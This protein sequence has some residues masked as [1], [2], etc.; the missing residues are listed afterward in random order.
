M[1]NVLEKRQ[2]ESQTRRVLNE[3][4]GEAESGARGGGMV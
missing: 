1:D 3:R 4:I 2:K